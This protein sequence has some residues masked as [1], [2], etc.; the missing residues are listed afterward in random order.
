MGT[1]KGLTIARLKQIFRR[2]KNPTWGE[3]YQ[4]S[5]K[6]ERG[7]APA[8]SHAFKLG[9]WKVSGRY[10]HLLSSPELAAALIGLYHPGVV[11][12]QEQRMLSPAPKEH[13]L[14]NFPGCIAG[15]LLPFQGMVAVAQRLDCLDALPKVWGDDPMCE[16]GKRELI[17]PYLGDLLWAV[18][19]ADGHIYCVNWSV[20]SREED[21]K[22]PFDDR[23]LSRLSPQPS[24]KEQ[25]RHELETIYYADA[26]IRTVHVA[27]EAI[28]PHVTG[29]LRTLFLW[30]NR[31][32][33]LSLDQQTDLLHRFRTCIDTGM[34]PL[35]VIVRLGGN[36]STTTND[37]CNVFYQSIWRRKLRVDLFRPVLI[38]RPLRPEA[39]DVLARY[40]GWFE[41]KPC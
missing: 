25:L 41:E 1:S 7:E 35:E 5:T 6:A 31:A 11:G 23:W 34:T 33:N 19:A 18:R 9:P 10:I 3:D 26:G 39:E 20:K 24:A 17:F 15:G 4:P 32:V 14:T 8:K 2:Q 22:R 16:T 36:G 27:G 37:Y 28:D 30:H 12:L 38:D 40:A 13:P 29:N 21:F